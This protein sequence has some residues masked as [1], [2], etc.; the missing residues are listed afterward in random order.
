MRWSRLAIR[1]WT[2]PKKQD[3]AENEIRHSGAITKARIVSGLLRAVRQD[4][5]LPDN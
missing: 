3:P 1:A 4:I 5:L 2:S